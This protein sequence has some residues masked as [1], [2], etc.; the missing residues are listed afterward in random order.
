MDKSE[1]KPV[2]KTCA[3]NSAVSQKDF[4]CATGA[5]LRRNRWACLHLEV[6]PPELHAIWAL[7]AR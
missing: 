3:G 2:K 6:E 5:P 4:G 7:T 1:M